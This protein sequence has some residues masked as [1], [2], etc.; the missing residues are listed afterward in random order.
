M[1][2]YSYQEGLLYFLEEAFETLLSWNTLKQRLIKR[3]E[4]LDY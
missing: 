2:K 1:L 4:K 3:A